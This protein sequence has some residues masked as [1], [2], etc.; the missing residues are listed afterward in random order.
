M[1]TSSE[2]PFSD[3]SDSTGLVDW[4]H[5][6]GQSNSSPNLEVEGMLL[7]NFISNK[8]T[9]KYFAFYAWDNLFAPA[10]YGPK[11]QTV[12]SVPLVAGGFTH[13]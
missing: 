5:G 8:Q 10:I 7:E 4:S 9:I 6:G 11:G 3:P 12:M 1:R 2:P 13:D